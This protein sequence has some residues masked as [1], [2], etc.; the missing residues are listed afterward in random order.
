MTNFLELEDIPAPA[1]ADGSGY[2]VDDQSWLGSAAGTNFCESIMLDGA[3]CLAAFPNGIV[4]SG[5]VLGKVTSTG[6]YAPYAGKGN[7]VQTVT[8]A[9]AT[10]GT[11]TLT[12]DG[13]TTGAIAFNAS[14]ATVQTALEGLSNIQPGDVVVGNAGSVYTVQFVGPRF[15]GNENTTPNMTANG[16][17]LTG[18]SPTVTVASGAASGNPS[19][20]EVQSITVSNA[21]SGTF[22]LVFEG[23]YTGSIAYNATAS[24]IQTALE[25]LPDINPGDVVV[26]GG[27]ASSGAVVVTFAGRYVGVDVPAL[28]YD[29]SNLV[30]TSTSDHPNPSMTI[31]TTTQGNRGAG[32]TAG[33][34][35]PVGHLFTVKD[36][37]PRNGAVRDVSAALFWGPGKIVKSKLPPNSGYSAAVANTLQRIRYV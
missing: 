25:G 30:N 11:F 12:Y 4:P 35:T 1:A 20:N 17:S 16:G 15:L 14:G 33:L 27:P 18:T 6:K 29:D 22:R 34:E 31:T 7:D 23:E 8:L 28:Q 24:V 32:A 37:T 5:T 36:V 21:N 9:N 10:G 26:S 13:E 3:L 2:V 19:A